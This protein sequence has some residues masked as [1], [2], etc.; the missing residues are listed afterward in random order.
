[1]QIKTLIGEGRAVVDVDYHFN[2]D[3]EFDHFKV[4]LNG[5]DITAALTEEQRW[6]LE[7]ECEKDYTSFMEAV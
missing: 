3:R 7:D 2:T 1:M 6:E 4:L 5:T